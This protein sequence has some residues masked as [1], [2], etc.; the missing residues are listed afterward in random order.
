MRRGTGLRQKGRAVPGG[1]RGFPLTRQ[2]WGLRRKGIWRGME[3]DE[4]TFSRRQS[5]C[6]SSSAAPV[7]CRRPGRRQGGHPGQ[8]VGEA[9]Y[10]CDLE[11]VFWFLL[12]VSALAGSSCWPPTTSVPHL[13]MGMPRGSRAFAALISGV[14]IGEA[15][16]VLQ[17]CDC[18][19]QGR[20]LSGR[21]GWWP[22]RKRVRA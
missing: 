16:V 6:I 12:L 8:D 22:G 14:G 18:W 3:Q 7:I 2:P 10:W 13:D 1:S 21:K 5:R 11:P 19:N 17:S 15:S 9:C 20:D 4:A